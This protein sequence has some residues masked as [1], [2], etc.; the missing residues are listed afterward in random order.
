[1]TM[2]P[3]TKIEPIKK[4]LRGSKPFIP[5]EADRLLVESLV[6]CGITQDEIKKVI[7]NPDTGKAISLQTLN[8][9]FR[10]ELE[11]GLTKAIHSAAGNLRRAMNAEVSAP[12]V[13]AN[14]FYLKTKGRWKE[15]QSFEI[16]DKDGV[17]QDIA[18]LM[19]YLPDNAR[20]KLIE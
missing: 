6:A 11:T 10:E 4:H 7:I 20:T 13:A 2:K 8:T 1:M 12:M 19:L 15:P 14:I 17:P 3:K 16:L 18:P 9:H 5:T